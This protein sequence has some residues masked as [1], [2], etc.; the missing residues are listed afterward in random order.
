MY[1]ADN[2]LVAND[3]ER[4]STRPSRPGFRTGADGAVTITLS[5]RPP[6]SGDGPNW[7]PAPDGPFRLGL[8]LYYPTDAVVSG[9]W[10]PPVTRRTR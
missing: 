4:Y 5:R 1:G 6:A 7:L 9:R 2:L 3:L 8:R 10:T